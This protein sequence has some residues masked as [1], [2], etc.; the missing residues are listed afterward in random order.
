MVLS[1]GSETFFQAPALPHPSRGVLI[2][3]LFAMLG[4]YKQSQGHGTSKGSGKK[5]LNL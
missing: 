5:K 3:Y 2:L 1:L 4:P